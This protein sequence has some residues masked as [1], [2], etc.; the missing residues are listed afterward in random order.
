MSEMFQLNTFSSQI[1]YLVLYYTLMT[2]NTSCL[3]IHL[4]R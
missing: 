2:T 4:I 3:E 1:Y